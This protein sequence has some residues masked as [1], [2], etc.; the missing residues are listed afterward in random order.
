MA[1]LA[2]CLGIGSKD[3]TCVRR[4]ILVIFLRF[5]FLAAEMA[6]TIV[7]VEPATPAPTKIGV[8][9]VEGGAVD[10]LVAVAGRQAQE[11][12]RHRVLVVQHVADPFH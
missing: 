10:R 3:K 5:R 4:L 7:R 9:L 1:F 11:R 8:E 12:G 6:R 2:I